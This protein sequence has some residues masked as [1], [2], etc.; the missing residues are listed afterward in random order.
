MRWYTL[1]R[2][3]AG[4]DEASVQVRRDIGTARSQGR[5]V[6]GRHRASDP[7]ATNSR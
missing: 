2:G 5:R 4:G 6:A 1:Y 7:S 3:R